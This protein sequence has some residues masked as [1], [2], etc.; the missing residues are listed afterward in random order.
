MA[1]TLFGKEV[2]VVNIG[3]KLFS[4]TLE[5]QGAAV[6]HVSWRPPAGGNQAA[7]RLLDKYEDRINAANEKVVSIYNDGQPVLL[8]CRQAHEVFDDVRENTIFHAG[9]PIEWERMCGPMKGAILG[10]IRFEGLAKTEAEAEE[11]VRA[12]KIDLRPNHPHGHVGPMTGMI[13]YHMPIFVVRNEAFGNYA[14]SS[15]NEGLGKV[16]RFGANDD[17]VLERL[18]FFRDSLAPIMDA[19]IKARGEEGVNLRVI[20]SQAIT[21]GDELHQRNIAASSL[22]ARII[23]PLIAG[24]EGF[25]EAEKSRAIAFICG[26]DQ[27][28]LNLAMASAKAITDPAHGVRDSSIVTVMCRNGTDFGVKVA[29]TGEQWFVAQANMPEGLYFPGFTAEDAG[30]DMGDSAILEVIGL[31]GIAMAAS[32]AV[33]RFVGAGSQA[34]AVRYTLDMGTISA[35]KST[36]FQIATMNFDGTPLGLDIRKIVENGI[37][38]VINTGIA[39]KEAGVGQIGAGVVKAPLDCFTQALDAFVKTLE[40]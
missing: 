29:A 4:D 16:M 15:I 38:P 19:A 23:C 14:Y 25:S 28:F 37:V 35:G 17:E 5:A 36:Q 8:A 1:N 31:G 10:A 20:I 7:A 30:R 18:A 12:G 3:L 21:M 9:P 26:N 34:D 24:L 6:R 40:G 11:L 13:T 33:V 39:H 27:F 32:P 22:F 2:N